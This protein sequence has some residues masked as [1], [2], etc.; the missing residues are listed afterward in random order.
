[1]RQ[2]TSNSGTPKLKVAEGLHDPAG[3]RRE[4]V[5]TSVSSGKKEREDRVE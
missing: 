2:S 3:K 4:Y 5:V 1:M